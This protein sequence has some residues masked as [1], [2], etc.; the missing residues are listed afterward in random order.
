[1]TPPT[2]PNGPHII[3]RNRVSPQQPAD[4]EFSV[5][6]SLLDATTAKFG[7]SSAVWL[8]ERPSISLSSADLTKHLHTALSTTLD[9]YP[10]WCGYL[11]S[12]L[13]VNDDSLPQETTSFP[14][15]AKRYGRVYVHYGTRTDPGVEF[16]QATSMATVDSL[17][18]ADSAKR[19][20]IW[21][22]RGQEEALTQFVPA[23]N[24]VH[25]IEPNEKDTDGLYKPIMAVQWTELACGGHVL[26]A[27]IAHPLADITAL[28]GFVR[29]WAS[30]SSAILTDIPLPILGPVFNPLRLDASAAG[31]I[32]ADDADPAIMEDALSLPLHRY[33]WWAPPT[34]P[35]PPFPADLPISGKPLPWVEWDTKAPVEQ[36]TIHF[37]RKQI[38]HLW[39]SV[40]QERSLTSS[41]LR[42]S[43][44]DA[45]LAHVWSC[46][47][48][49]RGLQD[50]QGPV[51]CDLVLGTRP[52]LQLDNSFIG[53]PTLMLNIEMAASHVASGRA[54]GEVAHRIR[55]TVSTVNDPQRLA[56]HLHSIA[57]EKSPQRIWQAFLGQRHILVTTWARAGIYDIDFGLGSR[58]RY[59]DGVVPC[60][61][62]CILIVDGPPTEPTSHSVKETRGWTEN[63]VDITLPLR[64][65]DMERLLRDPLLLPQV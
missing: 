58:I 61:D 57:Y 53:S 17:Y 5:P 60:L 56:A 50:D 41:N 8:L 49:A 19:R 1:M 27:K 34:K 35:P 18:S 55:E 11:K 13:T 28:A 21:N 10:Q 65:E 43:K 12:I 3:R 32:N 38:D 15:H 9:A 48:R 4:S 30:V 52:G 51:H 40:I 64:C 44:H 24:I 46:V 14:T 42:I 31:D 6:L 22:R 16:V 36:C 23:T 2:A 59:A 20:P 63:G 29:D 33:D 37:N 26:A 62:G 25:A 54:L 7:L 45:L 47:V 39:Q